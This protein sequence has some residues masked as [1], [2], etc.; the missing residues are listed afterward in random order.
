MQTAL[1]A[2]HYLSATIGD[3]A[4]QKSDR[5][6]PPGLDF[7]NLVALV[8]TTVRLLRIAGLVAEDTPQRADIRSKC[9]QRSS[10]DSAP[11]RSA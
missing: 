9:I 1:K 5:K 7:A 10:Q 3:V 11:Y 2:A 8:S 4:W 6:G